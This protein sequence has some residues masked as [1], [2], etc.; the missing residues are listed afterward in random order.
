MRNRKTLTGLLG[1]ALLL[2]GA[3]PARA[4]GLDDDHSAAERASPAPAGQRGKAKAK[5][6][7][8]HAVFSGW[9]VPAGQLRREPLAR[10]SG[11]LRLYSVNFHEEVE[12]DLY[13]SDGSF[14]E[15]ALDQLNH[16]WR[17]R[18]TGTEKP[19]DPRLFEL[20]SHLSDHF[21]GKRLELVSGF[22]NQSRTSSYHFH[23]SASDVRILGV[24]ERQLHEFVKTL[25]S[26]RM[27]L[28]LYPRAGFIHVD[29]RPDPSY[30]WIDYSPP[31]DN[32]GRPKRR[33]KS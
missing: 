8:R 28:G 14:N 19:I 23:G 5:K 7:R 15:A 13:N 10:P 12:V 6:G 31:G 32:G 4:A 16:F 9:Q 21:G 29:V 2:G 3:A 22:R 33:P 25:D 1:L 11:H 27:G 30:R 26:G 18:R 17:C 20:L 24:S